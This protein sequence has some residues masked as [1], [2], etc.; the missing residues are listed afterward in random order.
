[1]ISDCVQ[2]NQNV[3]FVRADK[4]QQ[5]VPMEMTRYVSCTQCGISPGTQVFTNT[6]CISRAYAVAQMA[7]LTAQWPYPFHMYITPEHTLEKKMYKVLGSTQTHRI[8]SCTH[9]PKLKKGRIHDVF[10]HIR[11]TILH[12]QTISQ[13]SAT[14]V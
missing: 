9:Q 3:H 7:W 4:D 11:L 13:Q 1:M 5:A 8:V 12:G 6:F 10:H 2:S 14:R